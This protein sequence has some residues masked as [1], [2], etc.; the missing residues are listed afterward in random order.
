MR[1]NVFKNVQ[2][3]NSPIQGKGIFASRDIKKNEVLFSAKGPIICYPFLPNY[4][5]GPHWLNVGEK[6]WLMP[7]EKTP[8][9]YV[10]HSCVPNVGL[11]GKVQVVAMRDLKEGEEILIDYSI[12]E[13]HPMWGMKCL[14]KNA[15]CRKLIRGIRDLPETFYKTYE[16]Y[17]PVFLK[18]IYLQDKIHPLNKK[19]KGV[20][21]KRS[22]KKGELI[23][24]VEGPEVHYSF[25]PN[26]RVGPTWLAV[27]KRKWIIP[28]ADSP[29]NVMRHSCEPNAGM[30]KRNMVVA[31]R[32]I[33]K[34]EELTMDDSITEADPLWRKQCACGQKNCRGLIRSIQFLPES[35]YKKYF[36]YLPTFTQS[37]YQ[38]CKGLDLGVPFPRG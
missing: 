12:T 38:E 3:R 26:Y 11:R 35:L 22:L 24:K 36:P 8:W 5:K 23:F 15:S 25:P 1:A 33:R 2:I 14:C 32:D 20:F 18:K 7:L 37:V 28:L 10:N 17:I 27:G 31:M 6:Q 21:A 30:M 4:R 9:R 29:W 34:D 13:S 16:P 19:S